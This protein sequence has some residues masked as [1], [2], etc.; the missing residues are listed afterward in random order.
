MLGLYTQQVLSPVAEAGQVLSLLPVGTRPMSDERIDIDEVLK[1]NAGKVVPLT[2]YDG[3]GNRHILGS[4]T[5]DED[6][7]VHATF[8]EG[9]SPE[10][11][12]GTDPTDKANYSFGFIT[13]TKQLIETSALPPGE[14][15]YKKG[16]N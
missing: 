7:K 14:V 5:V 12:F 11:V 4:A 16:T 2:I 15:I 8:S 9:Y 10:D 1:R 13:K 6:G 3:E